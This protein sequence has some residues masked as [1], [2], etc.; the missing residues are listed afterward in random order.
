MR[1]Y[2]HTIWIER[3]PEDVFDFF[4]DFSQAPR[5][6]RFV[7]AMAP[8]TPGP[9]RAGSRVHVDMDIAGEPYAFDMDVLAFERPSLWRHRTNETDYLGAIE[10]RF[11]PER[12]GTR[13]TMTCRAKPVGLYGWLGLP[14]VILSGGRTYRDQLPKLREVLTA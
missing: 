4:V 9:I 5:W 13:V 7:R 2:R 6:R 3:S 10:Y 8:V 12:G 14:L 11:E 1:L